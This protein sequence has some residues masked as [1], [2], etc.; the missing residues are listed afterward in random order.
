MDG[1]AVSAGPVVRRTKRNGSI[2]TGS[3]PRSAACTKVMDFSRAERAEL[4]LAYYAAELGDA[5]Q[6]LTCCFG[7][8]SR[9]C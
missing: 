4:L 8:R 2:M 6:V 7:H 9:H 5:L 3:L 1:H